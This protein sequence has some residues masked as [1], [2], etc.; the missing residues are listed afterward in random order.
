MK[1]I[2]AI[3]APVLLLM[4]ALNLNLRAKHDSPPPSS[5][6]ILRCTLSGTSY[7]VTAT[8]PST[9]APAIASS[10]CGQALADLINAGFEIN[11][12]QVELATSSLIYTLINNSS[13][14][15]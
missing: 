5:V 3:L 6:V 2:G 4:L 11:D 14:S 12:T 1:R 15:D 8:S 7:I 9:G 13:Q 10:S